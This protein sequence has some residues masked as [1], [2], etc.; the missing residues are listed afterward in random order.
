MPGE[1]AAAVGRPADRL[2]FRAIDRFILATLL[3]VL[4]FLII[5][6]S[7]LIGVQ[8]TQ[9]GGV[10]RGYINRA[11]TCD[12]QKGL[13]LHESQGCSDPVITPYRDQLTGASSSTGASESRM[14]RELVCIVLQ[15]AAKNPRSTV[16]IPPAYCPPA[17]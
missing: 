17:S 12:L 16:V 3:L 14:T 1:L 13:G 4:L 6:L 7:V 9:E 5:L 15:Q 10:Q 2:R 11:V 8:R